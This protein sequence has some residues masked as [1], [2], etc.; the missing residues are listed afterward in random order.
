MRSRESGRKQGGQLR[1]RLPPDGPDMDELGEVPQ[2]DGA[3]RLKRRGD[4]DFD[5]LT[6]RARAVSDTAGPQG[7]KAELRAKR[8]ADQHRDELERLRSWA[9]NSKIKFKP[10][11]ILAVPFDMSFIPRPSVLL[12]SHVWRSLGIYEHRLLAALEVEHCRHAGKEN[13]NLVLTYDQALRCG[14]K[15]NRFLSTRS[16]LIELKLVEMTHEGQYRE[17]AQRDPCRYRL[18]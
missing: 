1:G 15:R 10:S 14:I 6:A 4:L 17:A 9:R 5:D 7:T 13:G 18:T 2:R 11:K 3:P 8:E 12:S 16:R